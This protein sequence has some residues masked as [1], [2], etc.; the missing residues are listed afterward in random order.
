MRA[1]T[2]TNVVH[3]WSD[4]SHANLYADTCFVSKLSGQAKQWALYRVSSAVPE[5]FLLCDVAGCSDHCGADVIG[6][7]PCCGR[8]GGCAPTTMKIWQ[9]ALQQAR[10]MWNV[11]PR[12]QYQCGAISNGTGATPPV[13]LFFCL[14]PK[15]NGCDRSTLSLLWYVDS[16]W[17]GWSAAAPLRNPRRARKKRRRLR[18]SVQSETFFRRREDTSSN[19][20][21]EKRDDRYL[22]QSSVRHWLYLGVGTSTRKFFYFFVFMS[23]VQARYVTV[24]MKCKM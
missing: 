1:A 10:S 4:L 16:S 9:M 7:C 21:R 11:S 20:S 19:G 2:D 5:P 17:L 24:F 12:M 18:D 3:R 6:L 14:T 15:K 22:D 8:R 13:F 23:S